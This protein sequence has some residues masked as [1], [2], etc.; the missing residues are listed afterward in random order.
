MAER[1]RG[2]AVRLLACATFDAHEASA[3][4]I[5]SFRTH[6]RL[7]SDAIVTLWPQPGDPG[8]AQIDGRA[9]GAVALPKARVIRDRVAPFIRA[10]GRVRD[11]L[12]PHEAV[13]RLATLAGWRSALVIVLEPEMACLALANS[14]GVVASYLAWEPLPVVEN[15]TARLLA[16]YQFAARLV[17][18]LRGFAAD[19]ERIA[20]CGAFRHV[21]SAIVPVVEELDR[22]VDVLDAELV[23]DVG[24]PVEPGEASGKQLAWAVA[25]SELS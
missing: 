16:R 14:R 22:E 3:E 2:D 1:P 11:V 19:A 12:L 24:E 8:V 15:E 6:E 21:R 5:R 7:P 13:L 17:P 20:V 10:G 9:H 23:G 25:A 18:H 4:D